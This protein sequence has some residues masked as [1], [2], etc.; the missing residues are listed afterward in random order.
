MRSRPTSTRR[1]GDLDLDPRVRILYVT[2]VHERFGVIAQALEK[3]GAVVV[4]VVGGD[5]TTGGTV[6]EASQAVAAW[7]TLAPRVLAVAGNMDSP[8]IDAR[9]VELG[10]SID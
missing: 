1:R 7:Q 6:Q 2:D 8:E 5:L 10:V 3:A 9:L 4:L